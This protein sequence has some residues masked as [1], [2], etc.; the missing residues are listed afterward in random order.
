MATVKVDSGI[1]NLC[2]I[3]VLLKGT[4]IITLFLCTCD[5]L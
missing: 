2:A 3:Y 4:K 5:D 1:R